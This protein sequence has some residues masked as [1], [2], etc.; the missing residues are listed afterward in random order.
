MGMEL[1]LKFRATPEALDAIRQRYPG[2]YTT[3]QM[4]TTY[5]DTPGWDLSR[6]RWT[7]RHRQENQC[8]V[9]TLKTPGSGNGKARNETEVLCDDIRAAIPSFSNRELEE[10]ARGGIVEVCGARF[11][12]QA[13]ELTVGQ[14]RAELALDQGVLL[15]G[16]RELPFAEVEVEL[17]SGPWQDVELFAWRLAAGFRLEEEPMSKFARA[18]KLAE[19]D[20]GI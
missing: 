13:L 12:R 6:R 8:H 5:Y 7:L 18:R 1:E 17:K 3:Y 11:T 2:A 20:H 19:V 9:C 16:G 14:S 10:L 15:G 4:A